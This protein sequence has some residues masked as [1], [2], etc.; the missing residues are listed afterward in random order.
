MTHE[1]FA[2]SLWLIGCVAITVLF[3]IGWWYA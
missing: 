1:A 3:A 2:R